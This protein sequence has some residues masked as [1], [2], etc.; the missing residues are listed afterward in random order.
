[1]SRFYGVFTQKE[2]ITAEKVP[3]TFGYIVKT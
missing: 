1:M 2:S 3:A